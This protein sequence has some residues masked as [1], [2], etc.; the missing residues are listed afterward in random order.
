MTPDDPLPPVEYSTLF[1]LPFPI[2]QNQKVNISI[3]YNTIF[4]Q[5]GAIKAPLTVGLNLSFVH[6]STVP[7]TVSAVFNNINFGQ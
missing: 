4:V 5:G 3:L 7:V 2:N 1:F 6:T